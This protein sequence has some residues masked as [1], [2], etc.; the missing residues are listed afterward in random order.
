MNIFQASGG[1]W[2]SVMEPA[3]GRPDP[4][5]PLS[6]LALLY[7]TKETVVRETHQ[8]NKNRN[9]KPK[10][11]DNQKRIINN[12]KHQKLFKTICL[13]GCLSMVHLMAPGLALTPWA[14]PRIWCGPWLA[15]G[16]CNPSHRNE[17]C[18]SKYAHETAKQIWNRLHT[19]QFGWL[20]TTRHTLYSMKHAILRDLGLWAPRA[21]N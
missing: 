19:L 2:F 1:V 11:I 13:P 9:D 7:P 15:C 14:P 5:Q 12:K 18:A 21:K 20:Y 6:T 17:H 16:I 10:S 8:Q 4:L 3:C